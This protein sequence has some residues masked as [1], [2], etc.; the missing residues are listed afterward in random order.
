MPNNPC[1]AS[2]GI[3]SAGKRAYSSRS[4]A[5]GA[6]SPSANS[7][8]AA[9]SSCCSSVS[10]KSIDTAE[11]NHRDTKRCSCCA[12]VF[13]LSQLAFY[14]QALDLGG[15]LVQRHGAR[16]A[17]VPLHGKLLQKAPAAEHLHGRVGRAVCR[18]GRIELR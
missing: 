2:L 16:V 18:L 15:L 1:S 11:T 6:I 10:S 14:D 12:V 5:P 8:T 3:S 17:E 4:E 9:F 13:S 7:R